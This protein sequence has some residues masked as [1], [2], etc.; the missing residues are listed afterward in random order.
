MAFSKQEDNGITYWTCGIHKLYTEP[1]K[2][3]LSQ[4]EHLTSFHDI[5]EGEGCKKNAV[6]GAHYHTVIATK[7]LFW[8]MQ[9]MRKIKLMSPG[10]CWEKVHRLSS[11]L[12]YCMAS[13]KE[14]VS[15]CLSGETKLLYCNEENECVKKNMDEYIIERDAKDVK[16][17]DVKEKQY[18]I[19]FDKI[20]AFYR[21]SGATDKSQLHYLLQKDREFIK[22]CVKYNFN[23]LSNMACKQLRV[24][25]IDYDIKDCDRMFVF[26]KLIGEFHSVE[27][28]AFIVS[29]FCEEN[30]IDIVEFLNNVRNVFDKLQPKNCLYLH[31]MPNAGKSYIA[32]SLCLLGRYFCEIS[33][34]ASFTW[35]MLEFQRLAI[36]EEPCFTPENVEFF[37][38]LAE[39]H[40]TQ[41]QV[42]GAQDVFI[43]RT[44]MIVTTNNHLWQYASGEED[45]LRARMYVYE[46]LKPIAKEV[47][48]SEK[49]NP[50]VWVFLMLK[51]EIFGKKEFD[52][53]VVSSEELRV[54]KNVEDEM[55]VGEEVESEFS[56]DSYYNDEERVNEDVIMQHEIVEKH[57]RVM[58][59]AECQG[60]Q[61][62]KEIL[63]QELLFVEQSRMLRDNICDQK[64]CNCVLKEDPYDRMTSK[65]STLWGEHK[66]SCP[67]YEYDRESSEGDGCVVSGSGSEGVGR[68]E[69]YVERIGYGDGGEYSEA[70]TEKYNSQMDGQS[71]SEETEADSA[72]CSERMS[73]VEMFGED[74]NGEEIEGKGR[75]RKKEKSAVAVKENDNGKGMERASKKRS[76]CFES[77]EYNSKRAKR[78]KAG[79]ACVWHRSCEN[80]EDVST[81]FFVEAINFFNQAERVMEEFRGFK[82]RFYQFASRCAKFLDDTS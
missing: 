40:R 26:N 77:D 63:E 62:E 17:N 42:K 27:K 67:Y 54:L 51:Y 41:V 45:A 19:D 12:A 50:K 55:G 37:K 64:E 38:K 47:F 4:Y 36:V 6:K 59:E 21:E 25:F 3:I 28:S 44:P 53:E 81:E 60:A 75:S 10:S 68:E 24:E 43:D 22:M 74:A 71:C 69:E 1:M 9:A 56:C 18:V 78:C 39:G 82:K 34:S 32:R 5:S 16:G 65:S 61:F 79:R 48:G 23:F 8:N 35:Q 57:F 30:G 20:C 2:E 80:A 52:V 15:D 31:G 70:I 58:E 11:I 76:D 14:V 73:G 33:N 72:E 46:N 29:R 13:N 49:L 7:S 66:E